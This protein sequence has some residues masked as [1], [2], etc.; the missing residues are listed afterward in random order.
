MDEQK[1]VSV[2]DEVLDRSNEWE[3]GRS[4]GV[5]ERFSGAL[6]S[7]RYSIAY[8]ESEPIPLSEIWKKHHLYF[9]LHE[10]SSEDFWNEKLGIL[11]KCRTFISLSDELAANLS[12][13]VWATDLDPWS[14]LIEHG[15]RSF[16]DRWAF[17]VLANAAAAIRSKDA[18]CMDADEL[19]DDNIG[20]VY[21]ARHARLRAGQWR[22]WDRQLG[23]VSNTRDLAFWLLLAF[24]WCGATVVRNLVDAIDEKVADL[25]DV[26]WNKISKA[27]ENRFFIGHSARTLN[28]Y[29]LLLDRKISERTVVAF[30]HR[31]NEKYRR[32]VF[33]VRLCG[34][35]GDDLSILSYCQDV[36]IRSVFRYGSKE[37]ERWLPTVATGYSRGAKSF[38]SDGSWVF[39]PGYYQM[40]VN[41]A[42]EIV[43]NCNAYPV[44]LVRWAEH[45]CRTEIGEKVVPVGRGCEH[46]RLVRG[47]RSGNVS[48]GVCMYCNG[49]HLTPPPFRLRFG[50]GSLMRPF[51]LPLRW[52]RRSSWREADPPGTPARGAYVHASAHSR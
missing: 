12:G 37:W 15:C 19:F 50:L 13:A 20:V 22:W 24:S 41:V 43:T 52:P 18:R 48:F 2:I 26:W 7:Q 3:F 49:G 10:Q 42:K 16:G 17:L 11:E 44:T 31:V 1:I 32:R 40:P 9:G 28:I 14:R 33:E 34:Y 45:C 30:A 39:G 4:E 5:L 35:D 23:K 36:A 29:D 27:L 6:S 47:V 25:D 38:V 21:R 8:R 51:V 46:G